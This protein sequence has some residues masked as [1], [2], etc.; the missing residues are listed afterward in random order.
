LVA[1]RNVVAVDSVCSRIMG[2]DP[3]AVPHIA[4]AARQGAGPMGLE[5]IEVVGDDWKTCVHRF[6]APYSL[7]ATLK[8]LK[9]IREVYLG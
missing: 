1:G 2:Y 5:E 9:A 4:E 7:R 8:S 3:S 6:E